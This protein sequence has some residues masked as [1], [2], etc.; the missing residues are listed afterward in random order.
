[1]RKALLSHVKR[2]VVKIGSGV[3]SNEHGL[4]KDRV[5]AI[6]T[7]VCK[8]LDRGLEV[9][10]VSSA[11]FPP[12]RGGSWE[13]LAGHRPF[14]KNRQPRRLDRHASFIP[15]ATLFRKTSIM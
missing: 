10:V 14:R 13:S 8:L 5:A 1:M 9:I 2:V 15:T 11:L 12:A 7:D 3:I 6:A 4:E